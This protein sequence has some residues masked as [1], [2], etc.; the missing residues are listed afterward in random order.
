MT[1]IKR[2]FISAC[3]M[4]LFVCLHVTLAASSPAQ[5]NHEIDESRAVANN[6]RFLSRLLQRPREGTVFDRVYGFHVDR[7]TLEQYVESLGL[8]TR[9]D[10]AD[11]A[12]SILLGMVEM[13]RGRDAAARTAFEQGETIRPSDPIPSW[14]LGKALLALGESERAAEALE[15]ALTCRPERA[16]LGEIY[17]LLGRIYQ[18]AQK[19]EQALGVWKRFEA[20]F[21]DDERIH[22]QIATI[23]IDEQQLEEALERLTVLANSASDPSRRVKFGIDAAELKL[24]MGRRAEALADFEKQVALLKPGSWLFNDVRQRIEGSFLRSDDYAGL[25]DYYEAWVVRH[26][27]D[28]DAMARIGRYLSVQGRSETALQWYR[29]AIARAPSDRKLREALI[30]QLISGH[31]YAEAISEYERLAEYDGGNSDHIEPWGMLYLKRDDLPAAERRAR[32]AEIWKT[33]LQEKADDAVLVSRVADLFRTAS[34]ADEAITLYQKAVEL[35]PANPQYREYLGEFFHVLKRPDDAIQMWESMV[36]GDQ[37][38]TENL[39]RLSEVYHGFDYPGDALRTMS[40]ACDMDPEFG[41][42]IRYG[43]MLRDASVI[44]DSLAQLTLADE[45]AETPEQR[46]VVLDE[47]IKTLL[48]GGLLAG[49][50]SQLALEL[51]ATEGTADQWRVLTMYQEALGLLPDASRSI[52]KATLLDP[53]SISVWT[54][55]GRILEKSGMLAAASAAHVKLAG[56][57]R[58]YRTEH[59]KMIADL[60]KRLGRSDAALQAGRDF[61]TAAPG[62]AENY[63]FFADLC[64][65]LGRSNEGLEALRRSVRLNPSDVASLTALAKALA[66]Q[67]R[68]P[69]A[70]ELNWRAFDKSDTLDERIATVQPLTE[71]YLRTNHFDRLVT[72]LQSHARQ[73]DQHRDM[74]ICLANAYL[75]AGDIGMA[76][77]VLRKLLSE[78]SADIRLLDELGKLAE[79]EGDYPAAVDYQKQLNQLTPSDDGTVRLA[80]LLVRAGELEAADDLWAGLS[81]TDTEPHRLIKSID[82][83]ITVNNP[84]T[85]G[86]I[87]SRMLQQNSRDWEV[88]LRL[89]VIDWKQGRHA[90]AVRKCDQLLALDVPGDSTSHEQKY[91]RSRRSTQAA[92]K[93]RNSDS[94]QSSFPGTPGMLQDV[95]RLQTLA[96]NLN[97][98]AR[99]A[100]STFNQSSM[101]WSAD[102]FAEARHYALL[103]KT[104]GAVRENS[105]NAL[106]EELRQKAEAV[107]AN[108]AR[109]AWDWYFATASLQAMGRPSAAEMF[110]ATSLLVQRPEPEA[111]VAYLRALRERVATNAATAAP[112]STAP[113]TDAQ[114]DRMLEA[115]QVVRTT[116][117]EWIE[118]VSVTTVIAELNRGGRTDTANEVFAHLVREGANAAELSAALA[119][120]LEKDDVEQ[121]LKLV[122][123]VANDKGPVASS[124]RQVTAIRQFG[125]MFARI[126]SKAVARQERDAVRDLLF[127]FL[128]LKA[129]MHADPS[130]T[131]VSQQTATSYVAVARVPIF[132]AGQQVNYQQINMLAT[133]NYWSGTDTTFLVNLHHFYKNER[134]QSLRDDLNNY[135][136]RVSRVAAVYAELALAEFSFLQNSLDQAAVHLVRTAELAPDDTFLRMSIVRLHQKLG[137][138][139]D[140]LV[141]LETI[142]TVDQNML[143]EREV[144][145]LQLAAKTGNVARAKKAAERLF[146]LRLDSKTQITLATHLKNY[147][148]Q[149]M[150]EALLSRT[151]HSASRDM[152]TLTTLMHGYN[153]QGNTEVANEIAHQILRQSANMAPSRTTTSV[154]TARQAAV[155]ILGMS[156]QLGQLIQ[157]VEEQLVRSPQSVRLHQTLSEY[158]KA[159]GRTADAARVDA[160]LKVMTPES[161]DTLVK[162]AEQLQRRRQYDEASEKILEVLKKDVQRFTQDYY[163]YL[164][165]FQQA[166]KL[167]Q[168]ADV[169][170]ASDIR[171]L[172]NNY[173][174]I[175]ETIEYLF[176]ES[177]RGRGAIERKKGL[178]L[179]AAAWK[180]FPNNRTYMLSNIRDQSIWELPL[181]FDYV[182]EGMVPKNIQQVTANPWQGI[183]DA[184][185]HTTEGEITASFSRLSKALRDD[186]KLATFSEEVEA[187]VDRFETW[188]GGQLILCVLKAKAGDVDGATE[189][190]ERLT[191]D[192]DIQFIPTNVVWV[193]GSELRPLDKRFRPYI[194]TLME[195]A[196]KH[197]GSNAV[198][199]YSTSPSFWLANLYAEEGRTEDARRMVKRAL[200]S[201][202]SPV[203]MT[204]NAGVG[205][206]RDAQNYVAAG[207]SLLVFGLPFDAMKMFQ[208]VTPELVSNSGRYRANVERLQK[209][210]DAGIQKARSRMTPETV[211]TYLQ[212]HSATETASEL[213]P[214]DL[215]LV[216]PTGGMQKASIRSLLVEGLL[217]IHAGDTN[218]TAQV[219]ELLSRMA[220]NAPDND[221]SAAII[222]AAFADRTRNEMLLN[223]S[224]TQL[225]RHMVTSGEAATISST[226]SPPV[227]WIALW[228]PARIALKSTEHITTG[229]Q[230]ADLAETAAK[231]HPEHPW[232][233]AILKERGDLALATGDKPAAENAWSR[234]LDVILADGSGRR[235][236]STTRPTV[237]S[238]KSATS[239]FSALDELRKRLL[240]KTPD[241]QAVP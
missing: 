12:A 220:T 197:D 127:A 133:G 200:A 2:E 66:E 162:L 52:R 204:G 130:V 135:R 206:Y 10:D 178:E 194:I 89:A 71:L 182:R 42:R 31:Q 205:Q 24:R 136:R 107:I 100:Q 105:R 4:L 203:A 72:R 117:P 93:T 82:N 34:M 142:Q 185:V 198:A 113:L 83:L 138:E 230:L 125:T 23:L 65:Q 102:I 158:L 99:R 188:Y 32:A 157:R 213:K 20:T 139:A 151:R 51:S 239:E 124:A 168:L 1:S 39:V 112:S 103:I 9:A 35:E 47:R 155:E 195:Q 207:E 86:R 199:S 79:Q 235:A 73:V 226:D 7:G 238:S 94:G 231:F 150:A 171:K 160:Q 228:I 59:L 159:A 179:F 14:Y 237:T 147:G 229:Q 30:E 165:T 223:T 81:P 5:N 120:A 122:A 95:A 43:Q 78:E 55:A 16:E 227:D 45:M 149:E 212:N 63:Q 141:L 109:P 128:E 221:P 115:W 22:E 153:D 54:T 17:Q 174:V 241:P 143:K 56:L 186:E 49:R 60:E 121:F 132:S 111:K 18:R 131:P 19:H 96:Q 222:A 116:K 189:L 146:G 202:D 87:C 134:E 62:N 173:F 167:P 37:R 85:A 67:F 90:D 108:D 176:R 232:L 181:M 145:A 76:R 106:F 118:S 26:P 137:N 129:D 190:L 211:L 217:K 69:E 53:E 164:R 166:G 33:L 44:E 91:I 57:D 233:L 29:K 187:A 216:P 144:L 192:A 88:L 77:E 119:L 240:H 101:S 41:D 58:R 224:M 154:Q 110:S 236:Q 15:R 170:L 80:N 196:L 40:A 123:R 3:R 148:M 50:T 75:F 64:F 183:A 193:I 210:A 13:R 209:Q 74:T 175:N 126:A 114:L 28:L 140:A 8:R 61:I 36:A 225:N 152:S 27:D 46:Q 97:L 21:P 6:D 70:I 98:S 169:L 163:Q 214:L 48:E 25:V 104:A 11:G 180:A 219:V 38:T 177:T 92:A 218:R 208:K 201:V 161:I 191:A 215:M 234:M 84:D 184:M 68:T 156:G 172:N